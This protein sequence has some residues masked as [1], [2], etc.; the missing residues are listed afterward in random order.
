MYQEYSPRLDLALL[1]R[2]GSVTVMP[3]ETVCGLG[4]GGVGLGMGSVRCGAWGERRFSV[5]T[6]LNP[7]WLTRRCRLRATREPLKTFLRVLSESRSQNLT[8]TVWYVTTVDPGPKPPANDLAWSASWPGLPP[9][10]QEACRGTSLIRNSPS[11]QDDHR[12]LGVVLLHSAEISRP[13]WVTPV[14]AKSNIRT[15]LSSRE[16]E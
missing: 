16:S 14:P 13:S 8:L 15:P 7:H 5:E 11:P 4:V 12:T 2:D 6:T 9:S 1:F 3:R 10:F